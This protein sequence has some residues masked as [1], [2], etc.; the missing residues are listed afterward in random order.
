M[1]ADG[2]LGVRELLD[3]FRVAMA[4]LALVLVKRHDSFSYPQSI[5][6]ARPVILRPQT[7][8]IQVAKDHS[9]ATWMHDSKEKLMLVLTFCAAA[10]LLMATCYAQ[11][12]QPPTPVQEL[13]HLTHDLSLGEAQGAAILPILESRHEHIEALRKSG[14][15][16]VS[17]EQIHALFHETDCEIRATLSEQQQALF[18]AL[19]PPKPPARFNFDGGL[20]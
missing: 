13:E 15:P 11:Q 8:S 1:G 20:D 16:D 14:D 10:L 9:G 18:D 2:D 6:F 5:G 3:L 17:R 7:S 12:R 19:H 4:A